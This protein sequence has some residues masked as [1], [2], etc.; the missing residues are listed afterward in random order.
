MSL[1]KQ[2]NELWKNEPD[3]VGAQKHSTVYIVLCPQIS[4]TFRNREKE[5]K[6]LVMFFNTLSFKVFFQRLSNEVTF[7]EIFHDHALRFRKS[8]QQLISSARH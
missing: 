4:L 5:R 7:H 2:I 1:L 8:V 6:S 3:V